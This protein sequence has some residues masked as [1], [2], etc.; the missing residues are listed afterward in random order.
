M[1]GF[2]DRY[3]NPLLSSHVRHSKAGQ[4]LLE[5][6][7][8]FLSQLAALFG[9]QGDLKTYVELGRLL[10]AKIPQ[11]YNYA[12]WTGVTIAKG[13]SVMHLDK[14]DFNKSF[15]LIIPFGI[16]T[17]AA[18]LSIQ[19]IGKFHFLVGDAIFFESWV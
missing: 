8:P 9:A 14:L 7:P 5:L 2:W 15:C 4:K 6:L 13:A 11:K 19:P 18:V 10:L 16:F 3:G 12:I 1:I 17:G